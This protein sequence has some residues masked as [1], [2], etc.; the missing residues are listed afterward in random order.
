M[1]FPLKAG[2][3]FHYSHYCRRPNY[4]MPAAE[5]YTDFYGL[6]YMIS[7]DSISYSPE[8]ASV[9]RAGDISLIPQNLYFRTVNLSGMPREEILIKFT[10]AMLSDL[11]KVMKVRSFD[12][13]LEGREL[14]IHLKKAEQQKVLRIMK[15][16]EREWNDYNRYSEIILKG[17][18]NELLVFM[19]EKSEDMEQTNEGNRTEGRAADA[20]ADR[21]MGKSADNDGPPDKL[22]EA[23][24]YI[25]DHLDGSPS[26]R[27]TARYLHI[28]PSY[29]SKI[30]IEHLHTP[31]SVFV[32]NEKIL[33]AQK[34]LVGTGESMTE[35]AEKSG[36]SS[37][38]YFS[39][40][41]KRMTGMSPLQF[42]KKQM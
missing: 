34:L 25:K 40:C 9:C 24:A 32:L 22:L 26:L 12:E 27:E 14:T 29:L 16:M 6:S 15:E 2:Y 4:E 28:S 23:V 19:L 10:G 21:K 13:L 11:L 37:N 30:F 3:H 39:D 31:Y 8:G 7:G 17:L 38:T 33:Y 36:F 1:P 41:F 18:L 20:T 5:A 35:I 42:R